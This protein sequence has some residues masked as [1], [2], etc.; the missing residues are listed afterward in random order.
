VVRT[1]GRLTVRLF[2]P[3]DERTTVRFTNRRGWLVDLRA[4]PLGPFDGTFGL[5][6]WTIAT[7]RLCET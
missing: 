5:G 4:R 7:A 2:N 3:T 1:D 6:P